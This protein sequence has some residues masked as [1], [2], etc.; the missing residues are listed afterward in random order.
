M[1]RVNDKVLVDAAWLVAGPEVVEWHRGF[2]AGVMHVSRRR[3]GRLARDAEAL[4]DGWIELDRCIADEIL[5]L[6]GQG[7]RTYNCCCGHDEDTDDEMN[8]RYIATDSTDPGAARLMESLGYRSVGAPFMFMPK[9]PARR[10]A[11][12]PGRR[13]ARA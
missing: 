5:W 3:G 12:M 8:L 13:R 9:W 6:N 11:T 7:V 4:L 2:V 10:S 1:C